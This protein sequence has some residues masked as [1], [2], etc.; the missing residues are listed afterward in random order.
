MRSQIS[1][2]S[3]RS[4]SVTHFDFCIEDTALID[5]INAAFAQLQ[6]HTC[7]K[8]ESQTSRDFDYLRI[9]PGDSCETYVGKKG[10]EQV[11][12][13]D[14]SCA[15]SVGDV[16]HE[17][18]HTLAFYH[19]HQRPD[20][21]SYIDVYI[22]NVLQSKKENFNTKRGFLSNLTNLP[23]DYLSVTH[24]GEYAFSVNTLPT[25]QTIDSSKQAYIGQRWNLS[26]LDIDKVQLYYNCVNLP[27]VDRCDTVPSQP[28]HGSWIL[29]QGES[30]KVGAIIEYTC[31][32]G[33]KLVGPTNRWCQL[34]GQWLAYSPF[35]VDNSVLYCNFD[36]NNW[37]GWTRSY[38]GVS[39]DY[40]YLNQRKTR[41]TE[42]GPNNDHT[43]MASKGFFAYVEASRAR[44]NDVAK[45]TSPAISTSS[46][47]WCFGF[48]YSMYG[49]AIGELSVFILEGQT[50][51]SIFSKSGGQ[52][53]N[54]FNYSF[55]SL[56]TGATIQLQFR[57]KMLGQ[58]KG[59]IALDDLLVSECSK[60]PV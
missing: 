33:Y 21:N 15:S 16:L 36:E 38:E 25:I 30:Q 43:T 37:C 57:V 53:P 59:D 3:S 28:L 56:P 52:G 13:L 29:V 9:E 35:C 42:T 26:S 2:K 14:N 17:L 18:L 4:N 49:R 50:E 47:P 46:Q 31:E 7:I 23:Y 60:F 51:T 1:R 22:N 39:A 8:F 5:K 12:E 55:E 6:E 34:D 58:S 10:G 54:W 41:D 40:W 19:E 48:S 20:R 44:L 11:L 32:D 27:I 24:Y 45:L